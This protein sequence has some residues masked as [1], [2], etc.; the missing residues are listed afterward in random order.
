VCNN[1]GGGGRHLPV[2]SVRFE[3]ARGRHAPLKIHADGGLVKSRE[4]VLAAAGEIEPLAAIG[5]VRPYRYAFFQK[6]VV[7]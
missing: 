7:E 1:D 5:G 6:K 2:G 4:R 3:E